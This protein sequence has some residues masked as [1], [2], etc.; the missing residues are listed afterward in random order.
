METIDREQITEYV[1]S[2]YRSMKGKTLIITEHAKHITVKTNIDG[3]PLV[4]SKDTFK[5]QLNG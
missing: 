4:L 3:S 1:Y 2:N 5:Q